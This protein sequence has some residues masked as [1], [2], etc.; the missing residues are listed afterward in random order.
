M[1]VAETSDY[2]ELPYHPHF[3]NHIY[4]V[5]HQNIQ[6]EERFTLIVH[7]V[8]VLSHDLGVRLTGQLIWISNFQVLQNCIWSIKNVSRNNS[9]ELWSTQTSAPLSNRG[10]P[11]VP[12]HR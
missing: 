9:K 3:R 10:P 8:S 2:L 4:P 12:F 11:H 7:E 1:K 6:A 5:S